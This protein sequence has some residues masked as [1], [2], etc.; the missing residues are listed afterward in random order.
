MASHIM[1]TFTQYISCCLYLF[2]DLCLKEKFTLIK[3]EIFSTINL[4]F[5]LVMVEC[6][7]GC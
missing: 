5:S 3:T 6:V 4:D 1:L 2:C 7:G